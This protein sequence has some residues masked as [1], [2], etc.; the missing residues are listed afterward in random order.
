MSESKKLLV[1]PSPHIHS[2]DT[3]ERNTYDVLLALLPALVVSVL[4]FGWNALITTITS[5]TACVLLEWLMARF[6]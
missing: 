6:T 3:I 2:G 5:V 1:S 4:F